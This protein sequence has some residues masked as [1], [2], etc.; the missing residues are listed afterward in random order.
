MSTDIVYLAN[1]SLSPDNILHAIALELGL[2]VAEIPERLRVMQ[3][4]NQCLVRKHA[5]GRRVVM[6]VEEAQSMPPATM[7]EIRL[8]SNLETQ[9]DKLLQ[10]V[11]FGQ[12]ELDRLLA[13]RDMRQLRERIAFGF[14][15]QPLQEPEVREYL[16]AR[17]RAS[18]YRSHN[19]FSAS[20]VRSVAQA[21]R[22]LLRRIN[23]LADKALLATY[24][25][26]KMRVGSQEVRRA[27][28]DSEYGG[29]A[30]LRW[31]SPSTLVS[32]TLGFGLVMLMAGVHHELRYL[33]RAQVTEPTPV[34]LTGLIQPSSNDTLMPE[35]TA[36]VSANDA[37]RGG[38]GS[39]T[40]QDRSAGQA[41]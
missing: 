30:L 40:V 36:V 2:P 10:I 31:P 21:S 34:P 23:M 32:V 27:I 37:A 16:N 9:R 4:L 18:G 13:R 1:P 6:F 26:G 29:F 3:A 39:Q 33:P 17:L 5:Q 15:L 20:A 38:P 25:A 8:L 14:H 41:D 35:R 24:A 28:R 11:L 12:P 22:G 19:L 7:E